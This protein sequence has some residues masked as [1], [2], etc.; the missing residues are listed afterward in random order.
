M[1]RAIIAEA[2]T[3]IVLAL[4]CA[5]LLAWAAILIR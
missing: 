5:N 4:F 2:V 1:L 3:L